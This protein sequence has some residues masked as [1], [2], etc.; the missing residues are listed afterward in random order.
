MGIV[1]YIILLLIFFSSTAIGIL[2]SKKYV[3]RANELKEMR[4]AL[5]MFKTKIKY[6]Y[7]PIPNIFKE[8]SKNLTTSVS[9]I[10][11]IANEKMKIETAGQAWNDAIEECNTNLS[12]E[13][14]NILKGL[15]KLLGKT[16]VEGQLSEIEL[17][18][19]FI[20]TQIE[21]SETERAKNEKLY[22]TLGIVAGLAIV[23]VL[24]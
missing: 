22:K 15:G 9:N 16:D 14:L 13:D 4:N 23:I 19:S 21:K 7:E 12:R 1:K 17:T 3:N 6:T 24:I 20:D 5:N 8:I 2:L 18:S 11:K 10:F